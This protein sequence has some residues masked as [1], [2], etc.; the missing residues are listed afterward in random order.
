LIDWARWCE[1]WDRQQAAGLHA[2]DERLMLMLEYVARLFGDARLSLIDL[3]CGPGSIALRALRRFPSARVVGVDF[4]PLMLEVGRQS[5]SDPRMSWIEADVRQPIWVD[6][7]RSGLP[8]GRVDAILSATALH[9]LQP[10]ELARLYRELAGLLDEGGVFMNADHLRTGSS[11]IDE[12]GRS[13]AFAERDT[14]LARGEVDSLEAWWEG[15][16]ADLRPFPALAE[17]VAESERRSDRPVPVVDADAAFHRQA[18][19]AAGFREVA[20]VWRYGRDAVLL[21]VR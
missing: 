7:V 9:W 14:I 20:E 13:I 21:A 17:L 5:F 4:D 10:E 1:R 8:E 11:Q 16:E 19:I 12:L 6:A 2:R 18:L 15:I 3:C